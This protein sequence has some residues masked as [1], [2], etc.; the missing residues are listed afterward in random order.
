MSQATQ[1]RGEQVKGQSPFGNFSHFQLQSSMG[2]LR[3]DISSTLEQ[4][5][6]SSKNSLIYATV[7]TKN[8]ISQMPVSTLTLKFAKI[9]QAA[10]FG[11]FLEDATVFAVSLQLFSPYF[12][13]TLLKRREITHNKDRKP[14]VQ[15]THYSTALNSQ[16]NPAYL[17]I[18]LAC[19]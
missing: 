11:G 1:K 8:N 19:F 7:K 16:F 14:K 18:F 9:T 15:E 4:S 2:P 12:S 3:L 17:C 13:V 10:T 5:T 6:T